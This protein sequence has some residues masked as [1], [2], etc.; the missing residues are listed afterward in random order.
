MKIIQFR[1]D[2]TYIREKFGDI[3]ISLAERISKFLYKMERSED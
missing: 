2:A 3:I 1:K